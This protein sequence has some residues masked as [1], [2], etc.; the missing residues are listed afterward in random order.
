VITL[1]PAAPWYTEELREAKH[2]RRRRERKWRQTRLTVHHQLYKDQCRTVNRLLYSTKLSYFSEQISECGRD[3]KKLFQLTK[4][5]LGDTGNVTL[6]T[7]TSDKAL[8]EEFTQFFSSKI[9]TIRENIIAN[10]TSAMTLEFESAFTGCPLTDFHPATEDEVRKALSSAP[11]KSCE[12]DP[13]PTWLLKQSADQL[14][15]LI[16]VIVNKSLTTSQVPASFKKAVIRPLLKKPDL[17]PEVLKNY[18][19]VSNLPFLSKVLERIVS[20]RIDTH[21][22]AH[23]LQDF[24][25]SAHRKHFSPETAL[26]KVQTDIIEAL[27]SGSSVALIMLDLSAAFDTL[28]HETLL[29]RLGH[30]QGI[31]SGA[32]D[33]LKSYL[34][35]RKQCVAIDS[36]TSDDVTLEYGVPQ[37]SVLGPKGYSMYTLP[38]GCILRKHDMQYMIYADDS[39]S[40]TIIKSKQ[41][42]SSSSSTIE[43]CVSEVSDWM[44]ANQL[45][46]N[47]DKTEFIIFRPR[48]RTFAPQDYTINIGN[49]TLLPVSHVRNLGVIQDSCLTME[50][51]VNNITRACYYQIRNIGKIRRSITTDA[52]RTLIQASITSRLDYANVLLYGLPRSLLNRLQRVQNSAA[53]LVTRS[54]KREHISPVLVQLHWLPVEYRL[55]YK[56]LL[57]TFKAVHGTAPS[58]ICELIE[59][60]QPRR[61]LQ[62]STRSLLTVPKSRTVTYGD[63]SF[64]VAA[65]TLWNSLPEDMKNSDTAYSFKKQLKTHLFRNAFKDLL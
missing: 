24:Y 54:R 56:V 32:L 51:Q 40:Y 7:H 48:H 36:A 15:P 8:A 17:D 12:L 10:N 19:P 41:S 21:L 22:D 44:S 14:I 61:T 63:R 5:L 11:N 50:K 1:R 35:G 6:P 49:T 26:L 47:N 38:L 4:R 55:C 31:T 64:R 45:K 58:Y 43:A 53:R 46:L 25:Q 16:T 57:Y 37:G 59:K 39:Q 28:D 3:Q 18:R 23:N 52:C 60:Q 2:E 62:S 13:V 29:Q 27:D 33:W 65:A 34:C 9:S 42:W 30:S 20:K